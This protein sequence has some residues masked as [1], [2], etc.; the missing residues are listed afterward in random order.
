MAALTGDAQ[1][2]FARF[3]EIENEQLQLVQAELDFVT[4]S[5]FWFGF[6]EIDMEAI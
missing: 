1:R 2:M 6:A 3:L 5:G 4:R